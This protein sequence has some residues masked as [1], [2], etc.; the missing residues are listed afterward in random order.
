[1]IHGAD[2]TLRLVAIKTQINIGA[3][4]GVYIELG[5]RRVRLTT[6]RLRL[7]SPLTTSLINPPVRRLASLCTSRRLC[8]SL[9]AFLLMGRERRET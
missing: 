3:D 8:V 5:A 7:P 9:D 6:R 4:V 1:M 2:F